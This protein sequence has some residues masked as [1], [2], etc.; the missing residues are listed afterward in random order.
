[1][2]R[3]SRESM[4]PS[5]SATPAPPLSSST[6]GSLADQAVTLVL[7][8]SLSRF[9]PACFP[10]QRV[11]P[12]ASASSS[13][14]Q[15]GSPEIMTDSSGRGV[16][17]PLLSSAAQVAADMV[18]S[19][20]ADPRSAALLSPSSLAPHASSLTAANLTSCPALWDSMLCWPPI[21]GNTTAAVSCHQVFQAMGVLPQARGD[22][23]FLGECVC[24][25]ESSLHAFALQECRCLR[26]SDAACASRK[27]GTPGLW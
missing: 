22:Q 12:S 27:E 20:L 7:D 23:R 24:A 16:S 10:D 15:T 26:L 25:S 18:V 11:P 13:S 8:Y 19:S 4:S 14:N 6:E 5:S 3:V 1:M 17:Q 21:P 9:L 2:D